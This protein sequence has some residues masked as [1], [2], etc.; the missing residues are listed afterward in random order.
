ML[1]ALRSRLTAG[2]RFVVAY[3]AVLALNWVA[4]RGLLGLG[5]AELPAQAM[6]ALPVAALSFI[7]QKLFVFAA[8]ARQA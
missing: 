3:G 2:L 8:P 6:L 7:A 4:L 5:I 1:Y